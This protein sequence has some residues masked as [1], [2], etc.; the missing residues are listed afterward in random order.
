MC[1][2]ISPKHT[3]IDNDISDDSNS[4]LHI[5]NASILSETTQ[6]TNSKLNHNDNGDPN[7]ILN[8]LCKNNF[9]RVI[10][11]H[12]TINSLRN[13]FEALK[14]LIQGKVDIFVVSETKLDESFPQSQFTI[15]GFSTPFRL[16][17][18]DGGGIIFYVRS[19]IPCKEIKYHLPNNIEGI[20]IEL[21]LLKKK[22]VLFGG[23][24]PKKAHTQFP[25]SNRKKIR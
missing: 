20:F 1:N 2:P 16:D 12:L 8:E 18:N 9:G 14:T 17:R 7:K 25:K 3:H 22:W 6:P 21:S 24:N 19:S 23:Y 15:D 5:L 4:P 11:G 10:M 13:K